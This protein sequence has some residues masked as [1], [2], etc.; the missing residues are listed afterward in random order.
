M[1]HTVWESIHEDVQSEIQEILK[2][3]TVTFEE[4]YLGLPVPEGRMKKGKFQPPKSKFVKR[5]S[6]WVEKYMELPRKS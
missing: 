1:L 6:D 2:Y 5:A 4:K 3:E